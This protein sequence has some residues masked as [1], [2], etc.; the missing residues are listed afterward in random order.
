MAKFKVSAKDTKTNASAQVEVD[1]PTTTEGMVKKFGEAE[2]FSHVRASMV[3]ALQGIIR[4]MASEGKSE[5]EIQK[6]AS[7]WKPGLKKPG[8]STL[9]K[10]QDLAKGLSKEDREKLLAALKG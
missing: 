9:E 10:A 4:R 7:E 8:K 5:A 3:V 2:C 6:A 1:W